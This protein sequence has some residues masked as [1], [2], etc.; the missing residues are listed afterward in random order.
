MSAPL[1][2]WHRRQCQER[3]LRCLLPQLGR[4][5][6]RRHAR[7]T[8]P[9]AAP[10]PAVRRMPRCRPSPQG[11]VTNETLAAGPVVG[12]AGTSMDFIANATSSIFAQG[13]TPELQK[14]VGGKQ[15]AAG[16]LKAVQAEYQRELLAV[17]R[18]TTASMPVAD[19]TATSNDVRQSPRGACDLPA[20]LPSRM[21]RRETIIG[22]L[23]VLP[24]LLMYAVFVLLPL[25][26]SI[27][28]SFFRWDGIGPMTWVG[29]KNYADR[30]GG[31]RSARD[32]LQCV[33]AGRV[34]QL[35]PGDARARRRE[36]HPPRGDRA[37]RGSCPDRSVPA[38]GHPARCGRDHLGLAAGP[39]GLGQPDPQ[40][41]RPRRGHPCLARRLRLGAPGRRPHRNLG[42]AGFLHR[43]AADRH[44]EDRPGPL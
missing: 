13:W 21:V 36:R 40:G 8:W 5:E 42:P 34:L 19:Q 31:S 12:E 17:E 6:R 29:L 10:T 35:H 41:R 18:T 38:P 16:L 37:A 43:P 15:D 20:D 32:H 33:P 44:D 3:G 2:L 4:L 9:S 7:S 11:S 25:L 1:T 24:A 27:Q 39:P 30:P 14:M 28:Y 26:L 22:W 23:F